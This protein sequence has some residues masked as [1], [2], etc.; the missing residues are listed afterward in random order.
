MEPNVAK[1]IDGYARAVQTGIDC[2][3]RGVISLRAS[4]GAFVKRRDAVNTQIG[5]RDIVQ[6]APGGIGDADARVRAHLAIFDAFPSV[7]AVVQLDTRWCSVWATQE[8]E[9]PPLNALHA[10]YFFGPV[11]VTGVI[12]GESDVNEEIG[13]RVLELFETRVMAHTPAAFIRN[14]GALTW[15]ETLESALE[16]AVV[17]EE[18]ACRAWQ[19]RLAVGP[20]F[21][22]LPYRVR[23]QL[24]A[25]S[26][27]GEKLG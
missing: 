26:F 15:G 11:R 6:A 24:F 8:E 21:S 23:K 19:V 13:R 22:Y 4:G 10:R 5:E 18:L 25:G 1:L 2:G 7:N 9:L 20:E 3:N 14:L 17:L 16:R 12:A 27:M